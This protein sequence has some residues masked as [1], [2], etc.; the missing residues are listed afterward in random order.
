MAK[1]AKE[2]RYLLGGTLYT[3]IPEKLLCEWVSQTLENSGS[4]KDWTITM[5]YAQNRIYIPGDVFILETL[6]QDMEN[7]ARIIDEEEARKL[8]D[9]HPAGI[10]LDA[11]RKRFGDPPEAD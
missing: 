10:H 11:Y 6:V 9:E 5:H 1:E 2:N 4:G 7:R 8:M 3:L